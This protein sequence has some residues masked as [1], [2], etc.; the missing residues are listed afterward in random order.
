[1][2][3]PSS[4]HQVTIQPPNP[5]SLRD[6]TIRRPP[7][8][9]LTGIRVFAA[10]YVVLFHSRLMQALGSHGFV[11]LSNLVSNGGLAVVLF[12]LLSGFI[13]SYTY[14]G[15]IR[16]LWGKRRF[17][18]ARVARVWP[19]YLVS[20]LLSS[21]VNHTTPRPLA[22][23][24][25]VLMV[26]AWN[27]FQTGMAGAW[28]FVCWTLS[29]E[30]LFY[31]LFPYLQGWL[32]D[33]ST[34]FQGAFL[35]VQL[36]IA[37]V[38]KTSAHAYGY[39]ELGFWAHLPLAVIHIPEFFIGVS[40]GNLYIAWRAAGGGNPNQQ[41][42]LPFSTG[43]WTSMAS[44]GCLFLLCHRPGFST[45]FIAL[46]FAALV[47]GLAAESSPVQR[48]LSTRLLLVGGQ[49][50]Y[51]IYLLQWPVKTEAKL[52]STRLHIY[53]EAGQFAL[54]LILLTVI[55]SVAFYLVEEPARRVVRSAFLR[56][57]RRN[58]H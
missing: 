57:E 32:E 44:L 18:E 15:H 49:I 3:Q 29:T 50:S 51:G 5:S 7:L 45:S 4:R 25:T 2:S 56:L 47:F 37:T 36:A 41:Q 30:A 52:L 46:T 22:A 17:W 48:F 40:L 55:S 38:C 39:P 9:A 8:P 21:V 23:V 34:V 11:A 24:A 19:L 35:A 12:F 28:N 54:N 53:S 31:L 6:L 58:G 42:L 26:Q 16:Q 33:R 13:L 10:F 20:L 43:V 27:P 14:Q 1:M